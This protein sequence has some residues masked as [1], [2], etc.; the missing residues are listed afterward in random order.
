[1][2]CTKCGKTFTMFGEIG[3]Q[4]ACEDVCQAIQFIIIA[5]DMPQD[6]QDLYHKTFHLVRQM[7]E[8]LELA[9]KIL[10]EKMNR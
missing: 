2:I 3:M 6:V 1:M 9:H 10:L 7:P 8:L 5:V 4:H